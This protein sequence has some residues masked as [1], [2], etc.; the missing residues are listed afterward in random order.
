M[1]RREPH[2]PKEGVRGPC[3]GGVISFIPGSSSL[4]FQP[5]LHSHEQN[6]GCKKLTEYF[7]PINFQQSF[8]V[9]L[10]SLNMK[11]VF[12]RSPAA[13][14][15]VSRRETGSLSRVIKKSAARPSF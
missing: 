5:H 8:P 6:F 1:V 12:S 4:N 11:D 14:N 15:V 10:L 3:C 9:L 2:V 7:I 13:Y